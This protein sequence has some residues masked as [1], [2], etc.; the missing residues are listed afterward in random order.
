MLLLALGFD[1]WIGDPAWLWKR[2]PHPVVLFGALIDRAERWGNDPVLPANVKRRN[3]WIAITVLIAAA[4]G[5]GIVLVL[6]L[7]ITG[8]IGL[9]LEA[10]I[11]G[12]FLAQRS[13]HEHVAAVAV[14]MRKSGLAGGRRAVAMIV[15]RDP[16]RLGET[17]VCRA[18]IE[19]LAENFADG[20]VAPAFWYAV[21]G[22][23]GL[24][25]YKMANTADSMIGHLTDRHRD[26]GR[27]AAKL[28]DLLNLFPARLTSVLLGIATL[29][30]TQTILARTRTD[31][32]RHRSPNAGW[33]EAAMA[34]AIDIAL[35]GPRSYGEGM[36]SEPVL[37]ASGRSTATA[38]DIDRALAVY[39]RACMVL[40]VLVA[41]AVLL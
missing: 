26:F 5:A 7:R 10:M 39:T 16:E 22:L 13:L 28:D 21:A 14:A 37:N 36:L 30:R 31:A 18:A 4:V 11:V 33:P 1:A 41:V 8:P 19:S 25:A 17:G 20:I 34:Y 24:L 12:V 40:S 35:G 3:G 32:P 15:G 29:G 27:G 38:A 9:L 2:L 23:P 6:S